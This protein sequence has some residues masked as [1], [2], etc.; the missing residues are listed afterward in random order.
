MVDTIDPESNKAEHDLLQTFIG[1]SMASPTKLGFPLG[2]G[3]CL[4]DNCPSD[5]VANSFPTD[6]VS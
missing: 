4:P 3:V 6:V 2:L 1:I 5:L